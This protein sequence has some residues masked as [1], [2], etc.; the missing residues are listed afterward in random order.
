[1]VGGFGGSGTP[2]QLLSAL[3]A[4]D[5]WDLTIIANNVGAYSQGI[6]P[7]IDAKQAAKVICSF[8]AGAHAGTFAEQYAAGEIE[9]ELVPQG[10]LAERIRAGG[11]GIAAF[12][13]PTGVGTLLADGKETQT[14]GGRE[15]ILE[16]GIVADFTLARALIADTHGNLVFRKA[17]RNFNPVM[18]MA[19]RC[20]LVEVESIVPAGELDPEA[21]VVPG[22]FVDGLVVRTSGGSD[23]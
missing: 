7:C 23:G 1:M 6:A 16:Y 22:I 13:T 20:S 9:L 4:R 5:V 21:I 11:A 17:M 10:T 3:A 2:T 12:Y 14:I 19:G 18:I 15:C 8:P